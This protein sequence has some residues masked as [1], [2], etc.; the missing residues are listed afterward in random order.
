MSMQL[1]MIGE[2][3]GGFLFIDPTKRSAGTLGGFFNPT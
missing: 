1:M 3:A 2:P